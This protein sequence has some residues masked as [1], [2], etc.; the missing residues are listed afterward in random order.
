MKKNLGNAVILPLM[1]YVVWANGQSG[2]RSVPGNGPFGTPETTFLIH[3]LGTDHDE[4]ITTLDMNGDGRPD[5]LS[6]AYWYENPGP[7][8][9]NGSG[10]SIATVGIIGTSSSPTAA[11]GRSTSITM[12]RPTWSPPAG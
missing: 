8:A 7:K 5:I 9:A 3:R 12:A 1:L 4:G 10:T 11:S 6:G 2:R